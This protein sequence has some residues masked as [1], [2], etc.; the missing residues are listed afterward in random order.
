MILYLKGKEIQYECE[1]KQADIKKD[2]IKSASR[3]SAYHTFKLM[4][5]LVESGYFDE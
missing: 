2:L 5:E 1:Y 3:F 4:R